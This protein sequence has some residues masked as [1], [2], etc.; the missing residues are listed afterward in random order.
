LLRPRIIPCLLLREKG[1]VKTV[2]FSKARYIGDPIN[3]VRIFNAKEVGELVFLDISAT[4]EKRLPPA[5]LLTKIADECFMPFGV[6]GGISNVEDIRQILG[7]GAEKVVLNTSAFEDPDLVE[8]AAGYFGSQ[9]IVVCIDVKRSL[10][11]RPRVV[12]R[13]GTKS[14][15]LS[16]VDAAQRAAEAGAGELLLQAVDRDGTSKGYDLDLTREVSD[17]VDIPVIASGGAG[18]LAD[19]R[20][21]VCEAGASAAAA[22]SLFVYHGPRRA[23]LIN[24]PTATEIDEAFQSAE[25][26]F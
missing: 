1:L 14:S 8:R 9:S 17:A 3:A 10:F 22:G 4:P 13:R 24:Y 7:L 12:Y 19:T 5:E 25:R 23:V 20:R 6:G 16:P 26:P 11:G 15:D 2:R 21:V 18:S